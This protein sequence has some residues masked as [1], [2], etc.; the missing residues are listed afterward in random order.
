[1]KNKLKPL[2][3]CPSCLSTQQVSLPHLAEAGDQYRSRTGQ[4]CAKLSTHLYRRTASI[5][6]IRLI[7]LE[8]SALIFT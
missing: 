6:G 2:S 1:M 3:A 8:Q 4:L 5:M 7:K